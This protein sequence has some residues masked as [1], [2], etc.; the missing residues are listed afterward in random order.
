MAPQTNIGSASP[1]TIGGED[2]GEVLGTK[3]ENDAAAY[4]RALTEEHGRN[5]ELAEEM[6]RDATNVTARRG[7][8][9]GTDRHR[10]GEH[11]RPPRAAQR[12]RGPGAEGF[13]ARHRGTRRSTSAT[14]RSSTSVLQIIV[15]PNVA[16]LLILAGSSGSWSRSSARAHRAGGDRAHRAHRRAVRLVPA[17]RD[18]GRGRASPPRRRASHRRD[19]A[20]D[21]GHH[22]R[23]RRR[24]A[25]DL[26]PPLYRHQRGLRGLGA[27]GDRH[28]RRLR[29][30]D[31]LG[32]RT[33]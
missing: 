26:G 22:G 10:R 4:V 17:S 13:D 23:P 29:R 11:R 21:S 16:F 27:A 12:L 15:N 30:R 33:R 2:I 31:H 25:R 5:P 20:S 28:R 18:R 32:R 6:V 3:I 8:R 1:I 9:S 24:R 14:C 7:T 19:A